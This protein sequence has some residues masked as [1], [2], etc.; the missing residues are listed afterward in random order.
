M[1]GPLG[2]LD[3]VGEVVGC[4]QLYVSEQQRRNNSSSSSSSSSTII[5]STCSR[6]SAA[7]HRHTTTSPASINSYHSGI[8]GNKCCKW[9]KKTV[10]VGVGVVGVLLQA[11]KHR[12]AITYHGN[13][14]DGFSK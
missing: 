4:S 13:F 7:K 14:P 1:G 11:R 8:V 12:M 10:V 9:H 3:I 6:L 2:A 5:I